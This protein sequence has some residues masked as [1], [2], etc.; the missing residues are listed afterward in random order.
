MLERSAESLWV[1]TDQGICFFD[2]S[3][4]AGPAIKLKS[5]STHKTTLLKQ[6]SKDT[7]DTRVFTEGTAL[8]VSPDGRWILYAQTDQSDSDL[9]LVENYR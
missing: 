3:G 8:S 1:L 7:K 2:I 5:F 9:M 4:P 6:F